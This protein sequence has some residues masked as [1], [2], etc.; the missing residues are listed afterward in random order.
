M[1]QRR[2]LRRARGSRRVEQYRR[3]VKG[4]RIKVETARA[5]DGHIGA[6]HEYA[7]RAGRGLDPAPP[8]PVV[9]YGGPGRRVGHHMGHLALS[10]R[11]VHRHHHQS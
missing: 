10:V 2:P 3:V 5:L 11:G 7:G 9:N 6:Q 4:S 1:A 8:L